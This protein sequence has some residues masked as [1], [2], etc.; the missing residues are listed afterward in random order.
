MKKLRCTVSLSILTTGAINYKQVL[1][2][3]YNGTL[4]YIK[5]GFIIL[6]ILVLN[7]FFELSML[8]LRTLS[9]YY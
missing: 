3:K 1:F 4:Q 8:G 6:F 2:C 7:L 5:Y 9:G